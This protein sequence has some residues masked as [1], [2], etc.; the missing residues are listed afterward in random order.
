MSAL[1][2]DLPYA[3]EVAWCPRNNEVDSL[4]N[5]DLVGNILKGAP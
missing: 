4:G 1:A 2:L 5:A 3:I